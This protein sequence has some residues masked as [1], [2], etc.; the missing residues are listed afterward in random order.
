MQAAEWIDIF[1]DDD[2]FDFNDPTYGAPDL[3]E[4]KVYTILARHEPEQDE[5][6]LTRD[7]RLRYATE[8]NLG[9]SSTQETIDQ[10]R[11]EAKTGQIFLVILTA[12]Q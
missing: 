5:S 8:H 9:V 11:E 6:E 2:N 12:R 7:L 1:L 10:V 4:G 3:S